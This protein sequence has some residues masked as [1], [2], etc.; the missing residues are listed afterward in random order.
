MKN[1]LLILAV[2]VAGIFNDA[3]AQ[4]GM[5]SIDTQ[6]GIPQGTDT[7]AT[8]L[9]IGINFNYYFF[10]VTEKLS[11]GG[12]AGYN[13][14]IISSKFS[15]SDRDNE[16][17]IMLGATSNYKL[18]KSIFVRFDL[19]YAVGLN[20]DNDGAIF[21]EPRLGYSFGNFDLFAYHHGFLTRS[22]DISSIGLGFALKF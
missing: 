13:T 22:F 20:E 2:F 16:V 7:F 15:G 17:F 5:M 19:G 10:E 8:D 9:Q 4:D 14:Y 11:I 18:S 21:Y 3:K 6:F 12:R 1:F